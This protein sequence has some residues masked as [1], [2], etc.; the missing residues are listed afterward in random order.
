M[1]RAKVLVTGAN[2]FIG[3]A[4]CERL[5]ADGRPVIGTVRNDL[6]AN[7]LPEG[8]ETF[9]IGD[10]GPRTQWSAALSGV[11]TV[12]HLAARVAVLKD[13]GP[14]KFTA[15]RQ[16]NVAGT[17][18]LAQTAAS[19]D[20]QRLVFMSSVKVLGEGRLSAYTEGDG[21]NPSDPYA[22]SKCEGEQTL[23]AIA[24]KT[25]LEVV[26]LRPP[27]VYGPR[28]KANFL[29]LLKLVDKRIPLPLAGAKN[30]RSLIYLGNLLDAIITCIRHPKAAGQT[31]LVSDGSDTSVPELIKKIAL[32]LGKPSRVF[33]F[34]IELLR[35]LAKIL[36]QADPVN[37]LL[38]SLTVNS[39][40]IRS[41]LDWTPPFTME[42]GL[43]ETAKWY[44]TKFR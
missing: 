17:R 7:R 38:D 32:A 31:Y 4:L 14:D 43:K 25:G 44:L 11:D 19:M 20:V 36:G 12:V 24:E 5:M 13:E 22:V 15:Y 10:I 42:D 3:R 40:K 8:L 39:S 18:T 26:V 41:E 2:G 9:T 6:A 28:V 30:Q 35:L 23:H 16:A 1:H 21:L 33:P 34:P 37:R 27:L 29:Q